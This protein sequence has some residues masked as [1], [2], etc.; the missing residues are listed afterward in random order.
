MSILVIG[1]SLADQIDPDLPKLLNAAHQLAELR[2]CQISLLLYG[3]QQALLQHSLQQLCPSLGDVS[4]VV[5]AE[6]KCFANPLAEHICELLLPLA[7]PFEVVMTNASSQGRDFMPRL[8]AKLGV[9]QISEISGVVAANQFER[10]I[11]AGNVIASVESSERQLMLTVRAA[12]FAALQAEVKPS[13]EW[14]TLSFSPEFNHTQFVDSQQQTSSRPQLNQAK[15]VVSGGRGLG[16]EQG[17][18]KLEQLADKLDAAVGASRA[19]VDAGWIG[20]EHQVGQTGQIISPDVYIAFGISGAI[21]HLAGIKDS[22]VIVAVNKDPDAPIY[23]IAD[24][25]LVGDWQAIVDEWLAR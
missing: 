24:Y 19:A 2:Q 12:S 4:K 1:Q 11:Y 16:N 17:F 3:T 15:V 18:C 10:P 13:C 6:H 23:D 9:G 8:A 21:Q 7:E 14:Q 22:K 5:V 20:N 25:G